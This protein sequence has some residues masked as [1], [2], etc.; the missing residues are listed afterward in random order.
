[1]KER[2][3]MW[4]CMSL[5]SLFIF[6][7]S[8][9]LRS[10]QQKV[11]P[12]ILQHEA[13]VTLKLVQVYVTDKQGS[14]AV[15]LAKEDFAIYDNGERKTITE[16]EKHILFLPSA[17]AEIQPEI[18]KETEIP[19]SHVTLNRKFFF[20]FD[21][22]YNN[23]RGILK[24]K[25]AA[26]HFLDAVL[27]SD[28]VGVLSYSAIK[29]MKLHEFLTTDHG[30]VREFLESLGI[31][32]I[33]GRAENLEEELW[34]GAVDENPLDASKRGHVFD[35]EA[36]P[37]GRLPRGIKISPEMEKHILQEDTTLQVIYFVQKLTDLAKALRY[38]PGFKNILLFSSGLPYSLI[39]GVKAPFG[40]IGSDGSWGDPLLREK[41]EEMLKE[42]SSSNTIIYTIDTEDITTK[43]K[44]DTRLTGA[45][46]LQKTASAT[47][48]KYFGNI[49]NYEEHIEKIQ[50]VTGCYYVLGYYVDD[51]WDG[52]Y[53]EVKVE[54]NR[55]GFK[56]YAQKGYFNP[57]PFKEYSDLE[58]MLHLV[59]LALSENPLFQ[60]PLRFPLIALPSPSRQEQNLSLWARVEKEK[61]RQM[62]E[63]KL[64]AVTLL[65][66]DQDNIVK[67]ERR[68]VSLAALPEGPLYFY[69]SFSLPPGTYKCRL[70][71][72]NL[73]SGRGAMASSSVSLPELR[74][75]RLQ[76]F[77]PLLLKEER[78]SLYLQVSRR[79]A[80]FPFDRTK[81]T[82]LLEDLEA[83][84]PCLY[85][86]IHCS[87]G[88]LEKPEIRL[89]V[90]LLKSQAEET[91]A[92][93]VPIS[94]VERRGER[95]MEIFLLRIQTE[96]LEAGEYI[97][98]LFA[99]ELTTGAKSQAN[100][101]FR[102]K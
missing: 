19:P 89:L 91:K 79:P 23:P 66:D 76:L 83:G 48:G 39:Y 42:L 29:G 2:W 44:S 18:I 84:T 90:N 8:P 25:K 56:V 43:I 40:K 93:A 30:R 52:K 37:K 26:L 31:K 9:L 101:S 45:F 38:L 33:A 88:G 11:P 1:M 69:S 81:Y 13:T 41:H 58:R 47:G 54:V 17:K 85:A 55:S 61:I 100:T 97:L 16:F 15:D 92:L 6:G 24:A 27:P 10:G 36:A 22:A 65:F 75:G 60:T 78:D 28:E 94:I 53:H 49:N 14:P 12:K 87:G 70:V 96:G 3:H 32:E 95:D 77:P 86:L 63:K 82:P 4:G 68:E 64:E 102:I 46:T 35:K 34:M 57:K 98:Y 20:L 59:D 80:E 7:L 74:T 67:I 73:E 62:G 50:K 72:R 21:F 99:E 5:V 51:Q 71:L